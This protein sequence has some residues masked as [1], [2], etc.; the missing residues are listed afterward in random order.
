ME[1]F[2]SQASDYQT[3]VLDRNALAFIDSTEANDSQPFLLWVDPSAPHAWIPPAPRHANNAFVDDV[4]PTHPDFNE[5]DVSDKPSWLRDDVAQLDQAAIDNQQ[6]EYRRMMGSL[7]AVDDMVADIVQRLKAKGEFDHTTIAF[8][9]DNGFLFGAHRLIQKMAPYEESIRVPFVM[10]GTG[11]PFGT[12]SNIVTETDVAPTLLDLA[13][14]PV[15]DTMD[16]RSLR[17]LLRHDGGPWRHDFFLQY[18]G[19]YGPFLLFDTKEQVDWS[20]QNHG[21]M[22]I[23]SYTGLR[24]EQYLYVQWYSGPD[25][26]YELYDLA[27]DPWELDNLIATPEGA[28]QY[29]AITAALQ[30]RL[31][32]LA[33]CAG[34]SCR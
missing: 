30:A 25:H 3:D 15:P 14:V 33:T 16:G 11:V 26:E 21:V 29:A 18:R 6:A 9:S 23:P 10:A 4:L 2:G 20:V 32:E 13:G 31:D 1:S 28:Q 24:T 12:E 8:M 19:T 22:Y 7:L 34:V 17:P 5:P 27:A